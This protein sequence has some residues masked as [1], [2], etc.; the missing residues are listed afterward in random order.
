[1]ESMSAPSS[2]E[3]KMEVDGETKPWKKERPRGAGLFSLPETIDIRVEDLETTKESSGSQKK[4]STLDGALAKPPAT[5]IRRVAVGS[6]QLPGS[7]GREASAHG[8]SGN[9]VGRLSSDGV[10]HLVPSSSVSMVPSSS[11]V[12]SSPRSTISKLAMRPLPSTSINSFSLKNQGQTSSSTPILLPVLSTALPSSKSSSPHLPSSPSSSS[13]PKSGSGAQPP[14]GDTST[15][16]SLSSIQAKLYE[17]LLRRS[18]SVPGS[19]PT[20]Q[21][22]GAAS[23]S[24]ASGSVMSKL[25]L[26]P[27]RSQPQSSASSPPGAVSYR[28]VSGGS[29]SGPLLESISARRGTPA[30]VPLIR[31]PTLSHTLKSTGSSPT[32][33]PPST[34]LNLSKPSSIRRRQDSTELSDV[35]PTQG[36][37]SN[38]HSGQ[39]GGK[40]ARKVISIG[41]RRLSGGDKPGPSSLSSAAVSAGAGGF[42]SQYEM[43]LLPQKQKSEGAAPHSFPGKKAGATPSKSPVSSL[44]HS[45]QRPSIVLDPEVVAN[46]E[47]GELN[48]SNFPHVSKCVRDLLSRQN[49]LLQKSSS[50]SST[51]SGVSTP[52]GSSLVTPH[53][54]PGRIIIPPA[55][56]GQNS[57]VGLSGAILSV[58]PDTKVSSKVSSGR[59]PDTASQADERR[60]RHSHNKKSTG[61]T[62]SLKEQPVRKGRGSR[63]GNKGQSGSQTADASNSNVQSTAGSIVTASGQQIPNLSKINSETDEKLKKFLVA[64]RQEGL[65]SEKSKGTLSTVK[66][67]KEDEVGAQSTDDSSLK[68][69]GIFSGNVQ[70]VKIDKPR[71]STAPVT[72]SPSQSVPVC[73]GPTPLLSPVIASSS[74]SFP[75]AVQ[76][77]ISSLPEVTVSP[78]TPKSVLEDSSSSTAPVA[79]LAPTSKSVLAATAAVKTPVIVTDV[80][81]ST[82][83][84]AITTNSDS[85][86]EVDEDDDG[87]EPMEIVIPNSPSSNEAGERSSETT[88]PSASLMNPKVKIVVQSPTPPLPSE[89]S[90]PAD[91]VG[92]RKASRQTQQQNKQGS[93]KAKGTS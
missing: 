44:A 51:S 52:A 43:Y 42:Q 90:E 60:E 61:S 64:K 31:V 2:P 16:A 40:P 38:E 57:I 86:I 68:T 14:A 11:A 55:P 5:V 25:L 73:S 15:S 48:L 91:D 41:M 12:P 77:V 22:S 67:D 46:I 23:P 53:Q 87:E 47:K 63:G 58:V 93:S 18:Q 35:A 29:A 74:P 9:F 81:H 27:V 37:S 6:P 4:I 45:P 76:V 32:S 72:S 1:M 80:F 21:E 7:P 71:V 20:P 36:G 17:T 78:G 19:S 50:L 8:M 49:Q 65:Q 89:S 26:S 28:V 85:P 84:A 33:S 79:V 82:N 88:A 54:P 66:K 56:P 75:S 39:V 70:K 59:T 62:S 83:S 13:S 69:V 10:I 92:N 3:A 24:S 30:S 34:P